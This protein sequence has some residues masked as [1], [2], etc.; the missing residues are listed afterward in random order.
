[1]QIRDVGS[2]AAQR[3]VRE[4]LLGAARRREIDVVSVW[5][6]DPYALI[7]RLSGS[8]VGLYIAQRT[9]DAQPRP[10]GPS[11]RLSIFA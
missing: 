2:G 11:A 10:T 8:L 1:M 3:Q 9:V 4:R 6:L 7:P 5:R